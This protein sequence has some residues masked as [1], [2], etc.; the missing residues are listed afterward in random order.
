MSDKNLIKAAFEAKNLKLVKV[1]FDNSNLDE[2][3]EKNNDYYWRCPLSDIGVFYSAAG[4][5]FFIDYLY[6]KRRQDIVKKFFRTSEKLSDAAAVADKKTFKRLSKITHKNWWLLKDH[7][8]LREAI[9]YDNLFMVKTLIQLYKDKNFHPQ[10]L[11]SH[12]KYSLESNFSDG[13]SGTNQDFKVLKFLQKECQNIVPILVNDA[14]EERSTDLIK[15][16]LQRI[17]EV[18]KLKGFEY[19]QRYVLK[20]LD[21]KEL[22]FYLYKNTLK[23]QKG[24]FFSVDYYSNIASLIERKLREGYCRIDKEV[25]LFLLKNNIKFILK[26]N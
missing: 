11:T 2:L 9:R 13:F 25:S 21:N 26:S 20:S 22:F 14:F 4:F 17:A 7:K 5:N 19:Q 16:K 12:L 8:C 3:F 1:L 24:Q 23:E 15:A 6:K 18:F 10:F